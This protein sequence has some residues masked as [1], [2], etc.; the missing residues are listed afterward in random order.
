MPYFQLRD[1]SRS[2]PRHKSSLRPVGPSSCTR[3]GLFSLPTLDQYSSLLPPVGVWP[4]SQ[5]QCGG[6]PSQDPYPSSPWWAVAPPTSSW[7]ACPAGTHE[8][9]PSG[10]CGPD[11]P[12]GINPPFGGL[13]HCPGQV[14][15]ALRTR[16]PVAVTVLLRHAAPRLAC[17]RPVASVHPEPG[18]NSSLYD[19][20]LL[21]FF[22][23]LC[24]PGFTSRNS[25]SCVSS[26]ISM[27]FRTFSPWLPFGCECKGKS[28]SRFAPNLFS[29]FFRGPLSGTPLRKPL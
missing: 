23:R 27:S 5:C 2:L 11:V 13:S 17:V 4:L 28:F 1:T 3:L 7:D 21:F 25:C 19:F 24:S 18:S 22:F 14:A 29:S 20:R 15:Y 6:P 16:A 8:C 12:C 10:P 9:L 26:S